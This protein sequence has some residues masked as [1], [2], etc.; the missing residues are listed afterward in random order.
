MSLLLRS[1]IGTWSIYEQNVSNIQKFYCWSPSYHHACDLTSRLCTNK[2]FGS[3]SEAK[4]CD[5]KATT[6]DKS[7]VIEIEAQKS[8][9]LVMLGTPCL[10]FCGF[11]RC[12]EDWSVVLDDA[13]HH[14][15]ASE[16][17]SQ[18]SPFQQTVISTLMQKLLWAVLMPVRT[19][20]VNQMVLWWPR[21]LAISRKP[22]PTGAQTRL[23]KLCSVPT[24]FLGHIFARENFSLSRLSNKRCLVV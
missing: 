12:N 2:I 8:Q 1:T 20:H 16:P 21:K 10:S 17:A 11:R 5:L 22:I 18:P 24:N 13:S 4:D 19:D 9:F 7:K 3:K 14:L 23:L 15:Y 6:Q